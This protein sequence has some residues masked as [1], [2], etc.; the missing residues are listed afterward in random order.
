VTLADGEVP[1]PRWP[2]HSLLVTRVRNYG[3]ILRLT[4]D[5]TVDSGQLH[6]LAFRMRRSRSALLWHGLRAMFGRLRAGCH[7]DVVT[8]L[9]E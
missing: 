4:D 5:V 1:G 3:G 6:V 9:K 7:L 8:M 2:A